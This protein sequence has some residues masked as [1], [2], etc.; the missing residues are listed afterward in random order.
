M[1]LRG[2]NFQPWGD[3]DLIFDGLTVLVGPSNHGKSSIH[4]AL[5]GVL[6]N[7][8]TDSF[9]R[10]GQD[11][12]LEVEL[13]TH[14]YHIKANRKRGGST[15]YKIF[16][17][18]PEFCIQRINDKEFMS[19]EGFLPFKTWDKTMRFSS[20][21]EANANL[22]P[23]CKVVDFFIE[24]SS[25]G[26]KVPDVLEKLKYGGVTI[27][28]YS[29][30]PIFAN[31]NKAQFLID[32]DRWKPNELNAIIGAFSS[33]EKLDLGKKEANLRLTQRKSEA[34]TLAIE[35]QQ[36][37]ERV[38]LLQDIT[39]ESSLVMKGV[40]EAD[41]GIRN[42]QKLFNGLTL[43]M[44]SL[45]RLEP[46][47]ATLE[48]LTLPDPTTA[49]A[50]ASLVVNLEVATNSFL[51]S[52]LLRKVET[53]INNVQTT[54]QQIIAQDNGLNK[55]SM[56]L[57]KRTY[58]LNAFAVGLAT[59]VNETGHKISKANTV[60]SSIAYLDSLTISLEV[61]ENL[62]SAIAT[63]SIE[64]G[65]AEQELEAIREQVADEKAVETAK[66]VCPKCGSVNE[67][68]KCK[69]TTASSSD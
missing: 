2:K 39:S 10:N 17:D 15:K 6:R 55:L 9:I 21:E 7:E 30:D 1:R 34:G 37:E 14:G 32:S 28:D 57:E 25:L 56:L 13:F 29:V 49:V 52:S 41:K 4:R 5:R 62:A 12:P 44:S 27:G 69:N 42:E 67:C 51:A 65:E 64:L 48:T 22:P 59:I 16:L 53:T 3:F 68:P 11:E 58:D 26:G 40:S 63:T 50:L 66:G 35:I 61:Q 54:W 18:P 33:T 36:A 38:A 46:L 8:I 60:V 47:Q 23:A 19:N 43:A 20:I 31:Q 45:T 24:Y